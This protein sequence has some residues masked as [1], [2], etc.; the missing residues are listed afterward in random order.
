MV[1]VFSLETYGL[2]IFASIIC[3][4]LVICEDL[5]ATTL[6]FMLLSMSLIKCYDSYSTFIGYVWL[7]IP[8]VLCLLFHF[9]FYRV[10]IKV[11]KCFWAI[12]AASVAT[13]TGGIG[14]L[15]IENFF[16]LVGFYYIFG[17][18]F[19]MLI[20][21]VLLSTYIK[22]YDD[23]R[24]S[25][26]LTDIMIISGLYGVFMIA[27][28]YLMNIDT[29]L[30]IQGII[31]MQ[32]RNNLS[33]FFMFILP[34][35][36]YKASKNPY[37]S[38]LGI[39]FFGC[40]LLTGSR[41]GLVFGGIE[42]FMCIALL[43]SFDK[44][45]RLPYI[46]IIIGILLAIFFFFQDFYSFFGHTFD[47]LIFGLRGNEKEIRHGLFARAF[48]DFR[49]NPIFGTG[50]TYFGNRDIFHNAKFA[51][52]WYHCEPLQILASFGIVGVV[53]Y[54]Y[55]ALTR[56][57]ILMKRKTYFNIAVTVSYIGI[58]MMSLV[59]PGVFCPVPY[60]FLVTFFIVLVEKSNE[61]EENSVVEVFK[62]KKKNKKKKDA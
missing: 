49:S 21:Y 41:G 2:V 46:A 5:M 3:L 57:Y 12:L 29:V 7:G 24:L 11:G 14:F 47:R 40:I 34:F 8:V 59:N 15:P 31:Y 16:S 27:S 44:R 48:Y 23:Y 17:I 25:D 50:L 9:I 19:G 4:I 37:F 22:A 26:R 36:Y 61:K 51:L 33:T 6:P 39:L 58:E 42:F 56:L 43:L 60:L 38:L 54:I 13:T 18:G 30:A 45:H 55:Q 20:V 32:W 52:C 35:A 62:K 10:K 53:A 28:Y 1:T